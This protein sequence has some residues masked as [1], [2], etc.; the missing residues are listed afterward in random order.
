LKNEEDSLKANR[1]KLRKDME[2]KWDDDFT[3]AVMA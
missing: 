3:A 2:K 1:E